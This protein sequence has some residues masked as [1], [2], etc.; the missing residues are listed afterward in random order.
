MTNEMTFKTIV[1]DGHMFTPIHTL[2]FFL[3]MIIA[4]VVIGAG[5]IRLVRERKNPAAV[6]P[7]KR[8]LITGILVLG[9][10]AA[11]ALLAMSDWLRIEAVRPLR[12]DQDMMLSAF[13]LSVAQQLDILC[14]PTVLAAFAFALAV[15]MS[16]QKTT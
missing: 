5:F 7:R 6:L 16:K 12:G 15:G 11:E 2:L 1:M 8:M 14:L 9:L 4:V 3:V 10:G 13:T